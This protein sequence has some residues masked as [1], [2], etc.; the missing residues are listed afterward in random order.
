MKVVDLVYVYELIPIYKEG[1]EANS[2]QV[3]RIKD[4]EG[5]SCQ[6]NIVVGKGLYNI[7]DKVIYIMPDYTI[8]NTKT[9]KEYYAPGGDEKKSKLGRKGRIRAIKF[10]FQFYGESNPIYSNGIL[11]P[12]AEINSLIGEDEYHKFQDMTLNLQELLG[13]EKYV[14]DDN[15]GNSSASGLTSGDRPSFLYET[16][17]TRMEMLKSHIEKCFQEGE[18]FGFTL[19][20]D[21]SSISEF[22]KLELDNTERVGICSRKLEKKLLQ[23]YVSCYKDGENILHPYFNKETQENGW[24][25]DTTKKFYTNEE[26][27]QFEPVVT[28]VRDNWV[29][30]DKKFGYLS[31]LTEYCRKYN[32]QLCLRGELIGGGI[33][34]KNINL[35]SKGEVKVVWFGIDDLTPGFTT[36][37]NYSQ[38]HNL[39]KVCEELDFEYTKELWEGNYSYDEIIKLCEEYFAKVKSETGQLVEGIVIR[40]KYSNK[41]SF[42][43]LN[44]EYDSKK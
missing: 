33:Q 28:E 4:K 36:R 17:E 24:F 20:R 39:V 23:E 32:T 8:P 2:I 29:D 21:G 3:A 37:I 19:K 12:L 26:V 42:K 6:F 44:P 16:D 43:Y 30:T 35:D 14:A 11:I 7:G 31:K 41:A 13:V 40:T 1:V 25:N 27:K 34:G 38:E 5:N 9:F 15:S 18:V 10:N 22:F